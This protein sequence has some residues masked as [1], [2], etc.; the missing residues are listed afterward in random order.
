V[1]NGKKSMKRAQTP[2]VFAALSV[3]P[4]LGITADAQPAAAPDVFAQLRALDYT[5]KTELGYVIFQ[6]T[7]TGCH[8]NPAVPRAPPQAALM[9]LSAHRIY[10]SLTSGV[11][12]PVVGDKLGEGARRA[13]A[14]SL[15]GQ[16]LG[17][18]TLGDAAH[19]PNRCTDN[20]ELLERPNTGW[21]GWGVDTTNSRFQ[22]AS[23]A[24]L[25]AENI[26]HLTLR[27]AFG[28]PNGGSVY[29][30][31]AVRFGRL[32]VGSDIGFVYSVNAHNGCVYWSFK[33]KDGVRTAM[34][35]ARI[36]TRAGH[37]QAVFFGDRRGNLYAVDA[38]R[39]RLL[40]S[41]NL[42]EH[43]TQ[44]IT[45]A[46]T[47]YQGRLYVPISSWE[48]AGAADLAYEC[49][50]S[51]GAVASVNA[52]TGRVI[53][54]TRVIP[55]RPKPQGR[56][57]QGVRRW[58]PAGGSV[59]N[60]PTIDPMRMAVYFGTG[61]GTTYPAA[62]TTDAVMA[63][64]MKSGRMLWT[65]QVQT[66]DSFLGGCGSPHPSNCPQRVGPDR[67]IPA[68]PV[69]V[70]LPNGQR[71]L[72]VG[73]KPGDVLALDPD[74]SGAVAWKALAP[75][76]EPTPEDN[77][78]TYGVPGILW[79][80]SVDTEHAYFGLGITGVVALKLTNG[81]R[82]WT[83]ALDSTRKIKYQSANTTIPGV[84]LQGGSDGSV[85]ALSTADGHELWT[86]ETARDFETVN[87]VKARGGS[88]SVGG[89]V[90]ADGMLFVGSG[91]AVLGGTPGNVLLAFAPE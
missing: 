64:D 88:I 19:M 6:A 13:V 90:A 33:A 21:N 51:V 35:L 49:C 59:W 74:K 89:P 57:E 22:P 16:R 17:D 29:A 84:V 39:G 1:A 86:F 79:G 80:F 28:F 63:L 23:A 32:Y 3:L 70:V 72:I 47:Y 4:V 11:M 78:A 56:N 62:P 18:A 73:T 85:H 40:W 53:W 58:G 37:V 44:R 31:P 67:D 61:D 34:T 54:K 36:S 26:S 24:G 55:G 50:R 27:W 68:S 69:L 83:S 15:S 60:S 46:P 82:A 81:E 12:A 25:N 7:C 5:D 10:D 20:P 30:Q 2:L 9:R 77:L 87:Q 14:E 65:Y 75:D 8:G 71:R 41:T 45:A 43:P 48:E 66:G 42:A 52:N 76:R 38:K 91:Y